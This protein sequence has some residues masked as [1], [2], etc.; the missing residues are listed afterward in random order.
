MADLTTTYM[1]IDLKNPIVPGASPLSKTV[2]GVKKLEDAGAP[3]VVL[4]SV[5]E[6]QFRAE[7][8]QLDDFLVQGKE[9]FAEALSYFPSTDEYNLGPQ[10][11][12]DHIRK[13]KETVNI[14]IIASLNGVSAQGWADFAKQMA[15]AGADGLEL[16][17]YYLAANPDL[18]GASIEKR[19][20]DIVKTVKGNVS[21]PVSV[22]LSPFFSSIANMGKQL[23]DAGADALV[24]FNRFYQPDINIDSLDVEPKII[25]S[26][27]HDKHLPMRWIAILYNR[28]SADLASSSGVHS[29]EDVI[30]LVMAGAQ[31]TQVT[32][33][34][35]KSGPEWISRTVGEIATWMNENGYSSVS[36]MIGSMSQLKCAEPAAFERA[37]YMKA[38]TGFS[39]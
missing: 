29:A 36:D 5:F 20:L 23:S 33:A 6:E 10:E 2:E 25:L 24:L 19:Y 11:Y 17:I 4:Y 9:S 28:I 15:E 38:L 1:G 8:D 37:N 18:D 32:S 22:K 26:T 34:L 39:A 13:C 14:P 27:P 16:N 35:L 30:Q 3:A 31:I 12:L 7:S 21:V